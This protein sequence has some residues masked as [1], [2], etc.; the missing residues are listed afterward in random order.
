MFS[1]MFMKILEMRP[2]SYDRR[3][4]KAVGGRVTAMKQAVVAE[5][6]Q[7]VR[8]LEI[9]CGTGELAEMM[10]DRATSVEGFDVSGTMIQVARERIESG[11][12]Q[13]R[14][15]VRRMGVE[16]MDRLESGIFG[17]VVSTLVFSELTDDERRYAL[18]HAFR[19]L[20]PGGRL[21]IADEVRPRTKGRGFAQAIVRGVMLMSVYLVSGVITRPIADL[22]GE[23]LAAGFEVENE[24][25]SHGDAVAMVVA[26]RPTEGA[27]T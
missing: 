12:L 17:S 9:G 13:D 2:R 14:M 25:R 21:V 23:V 19:V 20:A 11:N 5:V 24:E 27:K 3:I 1:Y 18:N 10:L 22:R 15:K 6:P 7:G 4:N 16:G 8:V 26:R